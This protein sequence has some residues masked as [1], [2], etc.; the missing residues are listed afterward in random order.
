[1]LIASKQEK[2]KQVSTYE[3]LFAATTCQLSAIAAWKA[4]SAPKQ[5]EETKIGFDLQGGGEE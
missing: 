4:Q 5:T 3:I 2:Q 1:M